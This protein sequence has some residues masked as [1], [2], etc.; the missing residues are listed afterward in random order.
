MFSFCGVVYFCSYVKESC[1][2]KAS[3]NLLILLPFL[4]ECWY[5]KSELPHSDRICFICHTTACKTFVPGHLGWKYP[6]SLLFGWDFESLLSN[7]PF[8]ATWLQLLENCWNVMSK[9]NPASRF[10]ADFLV[11]PSIWC[12]VSCFLW[13]S[14]FYFASWMAV[15]RI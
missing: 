8:S 10:Q 7:C 12:C 3:L 13:A 4:L 1:L 14:S 11:S 5:H 6:V 9:L 2:A 15:P